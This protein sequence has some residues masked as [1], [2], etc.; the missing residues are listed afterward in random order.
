MV[1]SWIAWL[2]FVPPKKLG[3]ESI[4]CMSDEAAGAGAAASDVPVVG[5][6]LNEN[7]GV[8]AG[9]AADVSTLVPNA[10]EGTDLPVG[11][12]SV[13]GRF[14]GIAGILNIDFAFGSSA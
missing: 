10:K 13:V 8:D 7:E 1:G 3:F 4:F 11:S 5:E 14:S 6:A 12:T 2:D 9:N